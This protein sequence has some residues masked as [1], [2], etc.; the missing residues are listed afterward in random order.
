MEEIKE[1]MDKIQE[2]TDRTR[3]LQNELFKG[4]QKLQTRVE[5][6]FGDSKPYGRSEQADNRQRVQRGRGSNMYERR[7]EE[8]KNES[9]SSQY[10][11]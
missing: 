11:I 9:M 3:K 7:E 4:M 8:E 5:K 10:S 2:D 6:I 1:Q